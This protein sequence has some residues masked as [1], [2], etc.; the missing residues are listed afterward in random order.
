MGKAK[1]IDEHRYGA[2]LEGAAEATLYHTRLWAGIVTRVFPQLRDVSCIVRAA[3]GSAAALPLFAWRR[4]GGLLVTHHSSFPFIYGGP[5][6]ATPA[7]WEAACE[8][9]RA[10]GGSHV[11]NGNPFATVVPNAPASDI[12]HILKLP[13]SP[14]AY[15]SEVLTTR[16]RNDIRRLTKKG[17]TIAR[18]TED[19]DVRAVY[20]L[21]LKRMGTWKVRPNLI[22]PLA[23]FQTMA[24]APEAVR[25]YVAR[26]EGRLIG[27]T[28]I[29][30]HNGI[31]HYQSGYFDHDA[32]T[33]RPNVLVQERIIRDAIE[34]GFRLYD[35]L[36]SAGLASVE[37]FKESFGGVRTPF[38]R[39]EKTGRRH[40]LAARIRRR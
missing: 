13:D 6:P 29:C 25:L 37:E 11:L 10:C 12:T 32:R 19:A 40:R 7:T 20:D 31:V 16:K 2:L 38:P 26:F 28:F 33:L 27:G 21:Y 39:W 36:P 1:D 3:N 23:L 22:Y 34:E 14:E 4:A 35:M 8:K 15:W 18:S 17:V 9:V 24:R 5:I 30:R